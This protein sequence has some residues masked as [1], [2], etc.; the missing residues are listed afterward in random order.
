MIMNSQLERYFHSSQEIRNPTFRHEIVIFLEAFNLVDVWRIRNDSKRIFKWSRGSKTSRLDYHF[1]SEHLQGFV[2]K[3]DIYNIASSDHRIISITMGDVA[4]IRGP[5][6]WKMNVDLLS[7][8]EVIE[9]VNSL[10]DNSKEIYGNLKPTQKWETIKFDIRNL[11]FSWNSKLKKER[12]ILVADLEEQ[13]SDIS[14]REN[15]E[16]EEVE[17]LNSLRRELFS[18]QKAREQKAYLRSRA[19]WAMYGGKSS[20]LFLNL[21]KRRFTDKIITQLESKTVEMITHP[22]GILDMEKNFFEDIYCSRVE[23]SEAPDPYSDLPTGTIDELEKTMLN[24]PLALD[25][26]EKAIQSMKNNKSS[27]SDG[28]TAEFYKTFFP[29]IAELLLESFN[30]SYREGSLN[31]EQRR[32][33]M[34][35]IPKKGKDRRTVGNWRPITLLNVDYKI[36]A[37]II[38]C[39]LT[40]LIPNLVHVNQPDLSQGGLWSILTSSERNVFPL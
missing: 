33:I 2:R 5:G 27:G 19:N 32:G 24:D 9:E 29:K 11:L 39:R 28:F 3:C 8:T 14:G 22:Q 35:L 37:K 17:L 13:I 26:L 7:N 4:G 20:K 31:S 12:N 6:F 23:N 25:E 1:L 36:L 40:T 18:I 16:E 21:E 34:S 10:I 15:L 38:S 30:H